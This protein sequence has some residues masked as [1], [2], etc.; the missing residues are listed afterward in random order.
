MQQQAEQPSRYLSV[1]DAARELGLAV[2][3][4]YSLIYKKCLPS[5]RLPGLD[6]VLIPRDAFES[7]LAAAK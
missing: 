4:V 6:R 1:Q 2:T 5:K 7:Y 3:T